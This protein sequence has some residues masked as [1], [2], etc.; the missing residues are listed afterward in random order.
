MSLEKG[1]RIRKTW[2]GGMLFV[3][4]LRAREIYR[5]MKAARVADDARI[6]DLERENARLRDAL[7]NVIGLGETTGYSSAMVDM[8]RAAL[9]AQPPAQQPSQPHEPE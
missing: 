9:T 7:Q 8:A 4:R 6:V 5:A 2:T 1:S 3:A